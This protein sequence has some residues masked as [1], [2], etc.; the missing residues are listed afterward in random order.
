MEIASAEK[1]NFYARPLEA[2]L[3]LSARRRL[4]MSLD[5]FRKSGDWQPCLG[6]LFLGDQEFNS[7][8]HCRRVDFATACETNF[9]SQSPTATVFC[10]PPKS[11][12]KKSSRSAARTL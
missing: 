6:D 11:G 8:F 2:K 7:C 1:W 4:P 12:V 10:V 3:S 5:Q 9:A